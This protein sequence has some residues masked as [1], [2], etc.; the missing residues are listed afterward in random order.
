MITRNKAKG[1]EQN[2]QEILEDAE[3]TA[4]LHVAKPRFT[5]KIRKAKWSRLNPDP[6]ET[7]RIKDIMDIDTFEPASSPP[8][9]SSPSPNTSH[10]SPQPS[11]PNQPMVDAYAFLDAIQL[12]E[13]PRAKQSLISPQKEDSDV[14]EVEMARRGTFVSREQHKMLDVVQHDEKE[15][16]G[17]FRDESFSSKSSDPSQVESLSKSFSETFLAGHSPQQQSSIQQQS[18]DEQSSDER[19]TDS[20]EESS[21]EQSSNDQSSKGQSSQ[22]KSLQTDSRQSNSVKQTKTKSQDHEWDVSSIHANSGTNRKA[23]I[24][25]QV[26]QLLNRFGMELVRAIF[27]NAT[28]ATSTIQSFVS[29]SVSNLVS[30]GN[31]VDVSSSTRSIFAPTPVRNIPLLNQTMDWQTPFHSNSPTSLEPS[32]STVEYNPTKRIPIARTVPQKIEY[33]PIDEE[34]DPLIEAI[35]SFAQIN[36]YNRTIRRYPP[37]MLQESTLFRR[38]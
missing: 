19:S 2:N 23:K 20:Q 21:Q 10:V 36:T 31:P 9:P 34:A 4:S 37:P 17:M 22:S 18:T 6:H 5:Y 33:V 14:E 15:F 11:T 28:A 12:K 25:I 8:L 27:E 29:E 16:A 30:S 26:E 24:A 3:T 38:C 32:K 35:P 7:K 1:L 13:K